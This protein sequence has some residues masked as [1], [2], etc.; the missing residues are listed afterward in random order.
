MVRNT[1]IFPPEP[2]MRIIADIFSYLSKVSMS[3]FVV[4]VLTEWLF[5]SRL[6]QSM[7]SFT[8]RQWISWLIVTT[9]VLLFGN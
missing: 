6:L 4:L 8:V 1:Y 3:D 2:S 7:L 5:K 9:F